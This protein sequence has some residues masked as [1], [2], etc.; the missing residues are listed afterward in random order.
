MSFLG[1]E[2]ASNQ[3]DGVLPIAYPFVR[4]WLVL[5]AVSMLAACTSGSLSVL[6][7]LAY[8]VRPD[9][10]VD[11]AS[12]NP[13]FEYLR[14]SADGRVAF[15]TLGYQESDGT[16]VYYSGSA[17]ALHLRN[18]QVVRFTSAQKR[19]EASFDPQTTI[20]AWAVMSPGDTLTYKRIVDQRPEYEFSQ[21]Q[22]VALTRL[23]NPPTAANLLKLDRQRLAWFEERIKSDRGE[24]RS[25]FA[26]D[27]EQS[28][29]MVVYSEQCLVEGFCL[30]LQRWSASGAF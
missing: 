9:A 5:V 25:L 20:S 3:G 22:S 12:L 28:T 15:L 14:T 17:E 16:Q 10:R 23:S 1:D 2:S 29:P 26:L 24:L 11:S 4:V 18:G 21:I 8:A 7:T 19:I 27:G 30:T 6:E 13:Q